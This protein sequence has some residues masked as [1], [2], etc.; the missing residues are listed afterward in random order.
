MKQFEGKWLPNVRQQRQH[1]FELACDE[2]VRN[3]LENFKRHP[4]YT[5]IIA[6]DVRDRNVAFSFFDYLMRKHPTLLG[7]YEFGFSINDMIGKPNIFVINDLKVSPGTLR[8]IK[9][10]GD[11]LSIDPN[12]KK[13]VEIGAGYGG[14]CL[15]FKVNDPDINYTIIDIPASL[16]VSNF[17][18]TTHNIIHRSV[19][20][21]KIEIDDEYDLCISD[22]CLSEFDE[23]GAKFYIDNVLSKCKYAYVTSN[24]LGMTLYQLLTLLHDVFTEVSVMPEVPKTSDHNNYIFICKK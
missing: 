8:F 15:T 12:I 11:I 17:Y 3:N 22:Y 13:I 23:K 14:Q 9:V 7:K 20:S 10:V 16:R 2:I 21:E 1:E 4:I 19:S 24:S 6:N 5:R 18:L